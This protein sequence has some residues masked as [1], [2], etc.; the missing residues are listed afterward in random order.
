[1]VTVLSNFPKDPDAKVDFGIDW[2]QWLVAGDSISS[3]AWTVSSGITVDATSHSTSATKIWLIG[4]TA[5]ESYNAA[6]RITTN[7]GR[8]DERTITITVLER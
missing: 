2:S 7:G 6:N 5:G 4:G 3:S 8:V 1:M